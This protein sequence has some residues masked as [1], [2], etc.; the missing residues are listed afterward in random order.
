MEQYIFVPT[1]H[2]FDNSSSGVVNSKS[3]SNP[4]YEVDFFRKIVI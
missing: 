3:Y 4:A 2:A 1:N